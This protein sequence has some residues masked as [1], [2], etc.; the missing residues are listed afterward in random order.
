VDVETTTPIRLLDIDQAALAKLQQKY[1]YYTALVIPGKT[2]KGTPNN[3]T[4]LVNAATLIVN[5]KALSDE[6]IYEVTKLIMEKAKD[7]QAALPFMNL[8]TP[9]ARA[10]DGLK[11][12]LMHPAAVRYFKKIGG[13]K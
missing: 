5:H 13:L 7:F 4:A 6:F 12:E 1:P 9:P 3:V 2:F 10:L 11:P 8:L